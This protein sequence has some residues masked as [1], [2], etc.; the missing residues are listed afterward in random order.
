LLWHS[1]Q[2]GTPVSKSTLRELGFIVTELYARQLIDKDIH[3]KINGVKNNNKIVNK[4]L[5]NFRNE[6]EHEDRAYNYS[7]DQ[8]LS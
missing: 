4:G 2:S 7:S 8:A 3:D 6:Y 1:K 5:R